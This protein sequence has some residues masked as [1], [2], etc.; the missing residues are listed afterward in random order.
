[1]MVS[2]TIVLMEMHAKMLTVSTFYVA[3]NTTDF[4]RGSAIFRPHLATAEDVAPLQGPPDGVA[5]DLR[6]AKKEPKETQIAGR[7]KRCE[8]TRHKFRL[9]ESWRLREGEKS[10]CDVRRAQKCEETM[11]GSEQE[12]P[13][14]HVDIFWHVQEAQSTRHRRSMQGENSV[15]TYDCKVQLFLQPKD[16]I[17][18][19]L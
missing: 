13:R 14:G 2:M 8:E 17:A 7:A 10:G 4:L 19:I 9:A 3:I 6:G 15:V 5:E 1:M 12:K 18:P 11:K 16:V